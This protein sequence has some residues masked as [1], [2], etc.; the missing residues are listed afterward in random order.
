MSNQKF[1]D[2][3]VAETAPATNHRHLRGLHDSPALRG[4][5]AP[6][7]PSNTWICTATFWYLGYH[8]V[9]D[10]H[11]WVWLE[12]KD[13]HL[14]AWGPANSCAQAALVKRR[15]T[16]FFQGA[17]TGKAISLWSSLLRGHEV[18]CLQH[19]STRPNTTR[20][21]EIFGYV[22]HVSADAIWSWCGSGFG[23]VVPSS[24]EC[25]P[26]NLTELCA[27]S[28]KFIWNTLNWFVHWK[29]TEKTWGVWTYTLAVLL[30]RQWRLL[31]DRRFHGWTEVVNCKVWIAHRHWGRII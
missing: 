25:T 1:E 11:T 20:L 3:P 12:I 27:R 19:E 2:T 28:T 10:L 22:W 30:A 15:W 24:E 31:H 5:G 18:S 8:F 14:E 29:C 4:P 17:D 7:T 21:L 16:Q 26:S 6:K 9:R 23:V 13:L